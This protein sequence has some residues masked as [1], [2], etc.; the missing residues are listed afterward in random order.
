MNYGGGGNQR[1]LRQAE[2]R[3]HGAIS[4]LSEDAAPSDACAAAASAPAAFA[5]FTSCLSFSFSFSKPIHFLGM[6]ARSLLCAGLLAA[7][8][9]ASPVAVSQ[10]GYEAFARRD[11]GLVG[12]GIEGGSTHGGVA[13]EA[14]PC[15]E[16][17]IN[18]L[19]EGG[20]AADAVRYALTPAKLGFTASRRSGTDFAPS[21]HRLLLQG[22]VSGSSRHT[23]R[24]LGEEGSSSFV[25]R[26]R[27]EDTTTR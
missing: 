11:G 23:T 27:M 19:E 9:S 26:P 4:S 2:P 17:G 16:I 8:V 18:I 12:R 15:S 6:I 5:R 13:T 20:S 10:S 25:F 7:L 14:A 24:A 3:V 21:P 1:E 22:C